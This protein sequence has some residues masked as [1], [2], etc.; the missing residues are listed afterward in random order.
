[1]KIAVISDTHL[2]AK[3]GTERG[4]DSLDQAR[5]AI[6]HSLELGAE[7]ILIPGDIFDSKTPIPDVWAQAGRILSIPHSRGQSALEL[8]QTVEK[9][10]GDIPSASLR[11]VPVV[12]LHGNHERRTRGFVN[13]VQALEAT[14]LLIHLHHS[15]IIFDTPTG[16]LAIHG[17]S[18][19]PEQQARNALALWSPRPVEG[20][21]NIFMLHQSVG[22]YVHS[23]KEIPTIDLAD[24]PPGFDLYLCG[25]VHFH[26]EV[27]VHGKPLLLPGSTERTQL[28]QVEAKVPKGFYML[29]LGDGLSYEFIELKC[30]RDFFYEEMNFSNIKIPELT[31]RVRAKIQ[32][33]LGGPKFNLEKLPLVRIRLLGTLAK[34]A[35]RSDFDE[36][37]I[38]QE[39]ADRALVVISKGD[40][41]SPGMEEKVQLLRDLKGQ[42]LPLDEMAMTLLEANLLEAGY[43]RMFDVRTLYDFLV[44]ERRQEEA[45]KKIF[46][47]VENLTKIRLG[48]KSHDNA[49]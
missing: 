11:G 35:S 31:S 17:M 39:F 40:L 24:L 9:N 33:F 8:S 4:K 34:E 41:T 18:N 26:T 44:E 29:D 1:M 47:V 22:K 42:R 3:W 45:L 13:P 48:K 27:K 37:A 38:V 20:A 23:E 7:L 16:K 14:G 5:E 21:L 32:E 28:L 36:R 15:T 10:S 2:G 25:H 43:S 12:A 49:G 30:V 46:E 6:E 19:V